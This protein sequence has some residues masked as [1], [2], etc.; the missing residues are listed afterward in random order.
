MVRKKNPEDG[1]ELSTVTRVILKDLKGRREIHR[2]FNKKTHLH[3]KRQL[4]EEKEDITDHSQWMPKHIPLELKRAVKETERPKKKPPAPRQK[5]S[6]R[7]EKDNFEYVVQLR[8]GKTM[9][10]KR[11]IIRGENVILINEE[12]KI[13]VP[14]QSIKWIREKRVRVLTLQIGIH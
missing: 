6:V 5:V 1:K 13:E 14:A 11:V 8:S 9:Q 12:M 3:T 10:S 4:A 7:K 2:D